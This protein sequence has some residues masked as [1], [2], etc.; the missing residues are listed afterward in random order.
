MFTKNS[1]LDFLDKIDNDDLSIEQLISMVDCTPLS[2]NL[3]DKE[4]NS[5]YCNEYTL[6]LFDMESKEDF[7]ASFHKLSPLKQPDGSDSNALAEKYLKKAKEKGVIKFNWLHN[8][9]NGEEIPCEITLKKLEVK[10]KNGRNLLISFTRDLR[11][12]LAGYE[13]EDDGEEFFFNI[14][15]DR[16]LFNSVAELSDEWFWL[17]DIEKGTIQFFGKGRAILNLS[18]EKKPFPQSVID[19]GVVYPEDMKVFLEMSEAMKKEFVKPYDVR[20]VISDGSARY[21]RVTFKTI[22]DKNR[23]P[24]YNVGKTFDIDSQKKFEMLSKTDLLTNC[25]NKI[26]TENYIKDA[27]TIQKNKSH[28]LFVV[29][30]DDFKSINDSLGHHFGDMVLKDISASL[31]ENFRDDDII[32]RIG[33]DEFI[34]FIKNISDTAIIEKKAKAIAS[35]FQN[36][37]TGEN[38]NYKVSGSI[39]ISLFPKD[40]K[41][42][43]ELYKAADKALY[44]SKLSGKDRYTFYTSDLADV[45]MKKLTVLENENRSENILH[46]SALVSTIF[47]LIYES[48]KK[49]VSINVVLKLVAKFMKVNRCYLIEIYNRDDNNTNFY[50]WCDEKTPKKS[51]MTGEIDVEV[52]HEYLKAIEEVEVFCCNDSET[53]EDE[54]SRNFVKSQGIKSYMV[55]QEKVKNNFWFHLGIDDCETQRIWSEKEI[56]TLRYVV[57]MIGIFAM[58]DLK[59]TMNE[60]KNISDLGLSEEEL[61]VAEKLKAKGIKFF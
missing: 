46:D 31:S 1:T 23:K 38:E 29:D 6:E 43:E 35:S 13:S 25:L 15:S 30:I 16:A 48:N 9:L 26:T 28:A 17:F 20:F 40:G 39:G 37:Y 59:K 8:K 52:F 50:E 53:I 49:T 34:V 56:S 5:L 32:G 4:F 44:K 19:G 42:Y 61:K 10:D 45:S 18:G 60:E 11:S 57:R 41:T 27:I 12:Q 55:V 33:G 21:Y 14:I 3:W 22:F 58:S 54:D 36:N 47:D 24:I 51:D 2:L 7:F